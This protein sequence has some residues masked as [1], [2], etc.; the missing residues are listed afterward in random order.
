MDI[1]EKL[2]QARDNISLQ[3][4]PEAW[5]D[6]AY[7]LSQICAQAF[8]NEQSRDTIPEALYIE[9]TPFTREEIKK[10]LEELNLQV[11]EIRLLK[12]RNDGI[13]LHDFDIFLC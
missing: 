2:A 8:K 10:L 1:Y 5:E 7:V 12:G 13:G 6:R 11:S 4:D 9:A 3:T